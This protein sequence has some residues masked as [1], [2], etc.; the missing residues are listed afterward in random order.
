MKK[1]SLTSVADILEGLFKNKKS[2]LSDGYFLCQLVSS[3]KGIAGESIAKMGQ[4]VKVTR[5][6]LTISLPSSSHLQ[7]MQFVKEELRRKINQ[8]FPHGKIKR[9]RLKIQTENSIDTRWTDKILS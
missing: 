7:E 6:E 2:V 5:Q 3:W 9:I 4:P 1:R 8:H